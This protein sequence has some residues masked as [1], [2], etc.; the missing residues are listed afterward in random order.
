MDMRRGFLSIAICGLPLLSPPA[1]RIMV[2]GSLVTPHTLAEPEACAL[3]TK[4]DAAKALE[5]SSASSKRIVDAD[6][7]GCVWS[8]DPAASDTSRRVLLVTHTPR[9]FDIAKRPAIATIKVEPVAGIGDEAFYQLYP[10]GSP[11][12]WA[13]K[14]NVAISI[15]ILTKV[16]PRPFADD[17]E[18]AKLVVLA[19]AAVAK[20]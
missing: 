1:T 2:G 19:K 15:R 16:K 4:A 17:Q 18:K 6:P 5:V 12:V 3:L 13:R 8:N 7:K 9:A 10:S 20:L 11:F 14:G